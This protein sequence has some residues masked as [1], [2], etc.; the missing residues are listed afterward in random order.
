MAFDLISHF[1][2]LILEDR[3]KD[4]KNHRLETS[5][6]QSEQLFDLLREAEDTEWGKKYGFKTIFSYQDFRERLP[7]QNAEDLKPYLSRIKAGETHL[8]W[9][10]TPKGIIQN[11]QSGEVPISEQAINETF[12]Q[13]I[14]DGYALYLH[15][16]QKSNLFN[17]YSVFVGHEKNR[18]Y[19]SELTSLLQ[20]NEPFVFSLLNMPKRMDKGKN[21]EK[22]TDLLLKEIRG[23]KVTC[24]KGDPEC[25]VEILDKAGLN[26]EKSN[27]KQLWADAEV[28][29]HRS[30][31][32]TS[33][34]QKGR[35]I[36]P[37]DLF[38]QA[39]YCS[40]EGFFGI[41]DNL[42]DPAYLMM[43]DLSLF[44]EFIPEGASDDQCIPLEDT[45]LD[46][47]YQLVLTNCS[48]LWRYRSQ[49]P[50]IRFISKKPYR[51]VLV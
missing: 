2:G 12:F 11:I 37:K 36:L 38:Y 25:L 40:P 4:I 20:E 13:G 18:S 50:K 43:L 44:Y 39:S 17:G 49:G 35:E 21:Q 47:H 31:S 46:I 15:Q 32:S 48:G 33:A 45:E 30:A 1:V 28:F 3:Y 29:F 41:Q 14:N 19:L 9:P 8:L 6:I 27:L 23:E 22:N 10:G 7:I 16:T 26:A 51:F 34:L 5:D 24:F 42:D